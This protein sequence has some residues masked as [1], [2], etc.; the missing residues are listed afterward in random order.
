MPETRPVAVWIWLIVVALMVVSIALGYRLTV[1][2]E[3]VETLQRQ[4]ALSREETLQSKAGSAELERLT[5]TLQADLDKAAEERTAFQQES[6]TL[7]AERQAL[8]DEVDVTTGE[9]KK[10]RANL[11]SARNELQSAQQALDRSA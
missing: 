9:L 7:K 4:L 2:E 1:K 6:E 3:R 8:Q 10:I 5:S 11:E